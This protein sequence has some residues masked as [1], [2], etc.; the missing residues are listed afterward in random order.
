MKK[1][2]IPLVSFLVLIAAVGA[3]YLVYIPRQMMERI[4]PLIEAGLLKDY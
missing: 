2:L 1:F 4:E 3:Y